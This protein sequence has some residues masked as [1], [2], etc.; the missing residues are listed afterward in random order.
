MYNFVSTNWNKIIEEESKQQYFKSLMEFVNNEYN[1]KTIYPKK[2]KIFRCFDFFNYEKLSV[3]I[4]GQDPYPTKGMADGLAF[5][6]SNNLLPKSLKNIF[7]ELFYSFNNKRTNTDLTDIAKQ[8]VLLLNTCLTV[9][10]NKP[11]SHNN[12]GWETFTDNIIKF[13]SNNLTGVIFLLMGNHAISKSPLI[14]ESKHIILKT[15][16]PSPLGYK[17]VSNKHLTFYHSN[18]FKTINETLKKLNKDEIKW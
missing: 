8:N 1:H 5:S 9:E 10:E 18:V 13:I 2:E 4:L 12:K 16:H 3:V 14:D 6:C 11:L 17:K 7:D 15:T